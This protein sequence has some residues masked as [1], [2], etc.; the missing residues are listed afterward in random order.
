[1]PEELSDEV[2]VL[3]VEDDPVVAQTLKGHLSSAEQG[4]EVTMIGDGVSA[5]IHIG[6]RKPHVVVLDIMMPG[7]DGLEVCRKIRENAELRDMQVIFVTG[8][9]DL[10]ADAI[11]RDTGAADVLFKPIRGAELR[12]VVERVLSQ[13]QTVAR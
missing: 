2:R 9:T 11:R 3:I 10:D 7:M 13:R 12:T 5:L 6:D 1:M 4:Y 8:R